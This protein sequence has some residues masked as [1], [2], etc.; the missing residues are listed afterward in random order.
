MQLDRI[1]V[2]ITL[3]LLTLLHTPMASA[4]SEPTATHLSL[5]LSRMPYQ[6][7]YFFPG[8]TEWGHELQLRWNVGWGRWFAD[9]NITGRTFNSAF[10]YV[11]W[12]YETG[13]KLLPGLDAVWHHKSEHKLEEYSDTFPVRD[14]YGLRITF[15]GKK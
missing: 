11:S 3:L 2:Q 5:Q 9:N 15:I 12:E 10:K 4:Y 13:F 1:V 8:Q 14:S 6:R 7:D